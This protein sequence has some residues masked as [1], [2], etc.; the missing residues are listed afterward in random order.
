LTFIDISNFNTQKF[1]NMEFMFGGCGSLKS[2][3]LSSFITKKVSNMEN[4]FNYCSS[5]TSLN[6][7][8]FYI[9]D[10]VVIKGMFDNCKHLTFIDISSF[11]R[12][13]PNDYGFFF[14]TFLIKEK[15]MWVMIFIII[16]KQVCVIGKFLSNNI[17]WEEI[18][19]II[20]SLKLFLS[21]RFFML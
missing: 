18:E 11:H 13:S 19:N 16:L 2:I 1:E 7:S 14:F 12:I 9:D 8:N 6:I 17:N 5:L 20:I 15:Y 10:S 3:N 4:M 21:F